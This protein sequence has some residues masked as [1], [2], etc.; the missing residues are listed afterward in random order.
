MMQAYASATPEQYFQTFMWLFVLLFAASGI[1]NGSTFRTI[2]VI[3]DR[4]QAG[5]VLGW[6]LCGGRLRCLHRPGD[7]GPDQGGHTADRDVR[8]AIFTPC[9]WC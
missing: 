1:G 5:P 4:T 8:I 2:G 6:T 9:V 3:F 7:W